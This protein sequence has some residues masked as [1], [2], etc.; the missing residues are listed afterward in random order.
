LVDG[1]QFSA[2]FADGT[3]N[4]RTKSR[5]ETGVLSRASRFFS[6]SDRN[7]SFRLTSLIFTN[8]L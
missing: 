3:E 5:A 8:S 1:H 4:V 7:F 2:D 6:V